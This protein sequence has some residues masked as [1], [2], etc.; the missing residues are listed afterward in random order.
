MKCQA[1]LCQEPKRQ[2]QKWIGCDKCERWLHFE[3]VGIQRK[4]KG[5]YDCG[6]SIARMERM[7]VLMLS[8]RTAVL[9]TVDLTLSVKLVD[10]ITSD[11]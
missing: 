8:L 2:R 1:F 5:N 6:C 9:C 11:K 4:P 3:C 7:E 10:Y